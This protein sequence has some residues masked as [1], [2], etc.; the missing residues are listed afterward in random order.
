MD[1]GRCESS[2]KKED[3]GKQQRST[4]TPRTDVW[5]LAALVPLNDWH[6]GI[7]GRGL[8]SGTPGTI[9]WTNRHMEGLF[10][11]L[12]HNLY[13]M[14]V[15]FFIN[16]TNNWRQHSVVPCNRRRPQ[17][18]NFPNNSN[19]VALTSSTPHADSRCA[20]S[21]LKC[22]FQHASSMLRWTAGRC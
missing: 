15:F 22:G 5:F 1:D 19:S 17:K 21:D 13:S 18:R 3:G 2:L 12:L 8:T 14:G 6:L 20:T 16:I 11:C 10:S 9:K 4:S 7:G